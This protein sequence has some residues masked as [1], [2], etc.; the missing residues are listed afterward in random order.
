MITIKIIIHTSIMIFIGRKPGPRYLVAR[1][2]NK[3]TRWERHSK[4]FG[5]SKSVNCLVGN[6]MGIRFERK[7]KFANVV[8]ANIESTDAV[9]ANASQRSERS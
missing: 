5:S 7:V 4:I 9:I 3:T 6:L 2:E 1:R 8:S